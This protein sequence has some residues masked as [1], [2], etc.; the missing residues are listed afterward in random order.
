M[1]ILK[2][3]H[4]QTNDAQV[5][6]GM[7]SLMLL[8]EGDKGIKTFTE[9]LYPCTKNNRAK[10][11]FKKKKRKANQPPYQNVLLNTNTRVYGWKSHNSLCMQNKFT[12]SFIN[13]NLNSDPIYIKLFIKKMACFMQP[14]FYKEHTRGWDI[15]P[16]LMMKM[17]CWILMHPS[18]LKM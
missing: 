15:G 17:K 6:K 14:E 18:H 5:C 4:T 7:F 2:K 9:H 8:G 11:F 1:E 13:I 12:Q 16:S 10:D 3:T